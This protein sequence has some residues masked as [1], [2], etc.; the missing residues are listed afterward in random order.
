[1]LLITGI[2]K[3]FAIVNEYR[4]LLYND[5]L[6]YGTGTVLTETVRT[7]VRKIADGI[8]ESCYVG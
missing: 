5:E 1:M 6:I 4:P 7:F 3:D 2:Q 8:Q